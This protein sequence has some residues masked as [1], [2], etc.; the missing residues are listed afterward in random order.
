MHNDSVR[1]ILWYK[2][3]IKGGPIYSV[4]SRNYPLQ[5]G[6]HFSAL[7]TFATRAS[8]D[9]SSNPAFLTIDPINQEDAGEFKCRVSRKLS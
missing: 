8:F 6:R 1:L 5:A 4:D 9:V 3:S 2:E 7:E